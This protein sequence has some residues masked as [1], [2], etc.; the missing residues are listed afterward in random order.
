MCRLPVA[1]VI[2]RSAPGGEGAQSNTDQLANALKRGGHE[3]AV[4]T[5]FEPGGSLAW[6]SKLH[7][8]LTGRTFSR[9]RSMGYP[10]F[11]AWNPTDTAE[12]VRRFRPD[13]A[14]VQNG[15]MVP[16][17]K[18]LQKEDVPVILYFRNVAFAEMGGDLKAISPF[19]CI[20]NSDFTARRYFDAYGIESTVIPPLIEPGKYR[21]DSTRENVTLINP[22]P[23]KGG[24]LAIDIARLCPDIPFVFVESWKLHDETHA[25]LVEKVAQVPNITLLPRT[26]DMKS[27]YGR[28]RILLAPSQPVAALALNERRLWVCMIR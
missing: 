28:A 7:R 17:A 12:V 10:V 25:A 18:S 2:F 16:I 3:P 9:D 4:L 24:N 5:A 15:F 20:S 14:V 19:A 27:I 1:L 6:R 21:T 11:R 22:S 26:D 23:L 8:K 13:V